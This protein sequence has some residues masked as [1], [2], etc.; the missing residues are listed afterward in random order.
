MP[1]NFHTFLDDSSSESFSVLHLN[2]RS[3]NKN[4]ENFKNILTGL[5]YNFSIIYFSET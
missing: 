2:I 5:K 3:M 4:F 1:K